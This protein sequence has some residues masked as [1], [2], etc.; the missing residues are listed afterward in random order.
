MILWKSKYEWFFMLPV[1]TDMKKQ[2]E[3]W[4]RGLQLSNLE[5]QIERERESGWVG[6]GHGRTKGRESGVWNWRFEPGR[7]KL[8][9][10][11]S[12]SESDPLINRMR[13]W[14]WT[15]KTLCLISQILKSLIIS[16]SFDTSGWCCN[17][18][19]RGR[20]EIFCL[21]YHVRNSQGLV[22]FISVLQ[23]NINT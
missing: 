19:R 21:F 8:E 14:R 11:S 3:R 18:R 20:C 5:R 15:H 4:G 2:Y 22:L 16:N 9:S 7:L 17:I 13:T 6:R 23:S 1:K 12:G 10:E